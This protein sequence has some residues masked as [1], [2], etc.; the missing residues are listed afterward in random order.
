MVIAIFFNTFVNPIALD[1]IGWKYYFVFMAVLICF[2]LTA[3]FFYPETRG[4]TL[5][6]MTVM[7]DGPK[8][9]AP[10]SA[11]MARRSRSIISEKESAHAD[12]KSVE[13]SGSIGRY[14]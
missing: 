12:E 3:Y 2:G 1:S 6:Q 14:P 10:S 13:S 7:F 4:Y 9:Q 11:E 5:E 8:A